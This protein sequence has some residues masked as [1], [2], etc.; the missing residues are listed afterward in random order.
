SGAGRTPG[1]R[2]KGYPVSSFRNMVLKYSQLDQENVCHLTDKS[3]LLKH[4]FYLILWSPELVEPGWLIRGSHHRLVG[5]KAV[6]YDQWINCDQVLDTANWC[7]LLNPLLT[8]LQMAHKLTTSNIA[9]VTT[10]GFHIFDLLYTDPEQVR[11][12]LAAMAKEGLVAGVY[13]WI[14]RTNGKIYVGS[15][16]NLYSRISYYLALNGIHGTIGKAL[17]KYGLVG[18]ILVIFLVPDASLVL[19]L[20]QSVLDGC[21][22]AYNILPTAGSS[23]G[24]K[25]SEETKAKISASVKGNNPSEEHKARISA[26][27]KGKKHSDERKSK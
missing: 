1:R 22:C 27:N 14:N 16:I 24:A 6:Q 25:H 23:A 7:C 10:M 18:F 8:G 3:S 15:S 5:H 12:F 26:A 2:G 21:I 11:A 4:Q 20:E 9:I 17:L 13:L 19:A